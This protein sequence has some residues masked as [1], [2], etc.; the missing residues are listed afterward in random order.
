MTLAIK[1]SQHLAGGGDVIRWSASAVASNG[2]TV[3]SGALEL[4]NEREA[5]GALVLNNQEALGIKAEAVHFD[6][7]AIWKRTTE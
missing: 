1:L 4:M 2:E 7:A 5:V 3:T 6:A